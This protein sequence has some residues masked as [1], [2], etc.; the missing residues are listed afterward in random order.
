MHKIS[1]QEVHIEQRA[2]KMCLKDFFP[3]KLLK[4]FSYSFSYKK[5]Y[6]ESQAY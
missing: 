4:L 3:R 2:G 1:T 5:K 6:F